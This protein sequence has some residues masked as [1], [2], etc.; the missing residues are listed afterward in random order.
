MQTLPTHMTLR[1]LDSLYESLTPERG[2]GM[3]QAIKA[4]STD[5]DI[6]TLLLIGKVE[7][8]VTAFRDEGRRLCA[9]GRGMSPSERD[10]LTL[11]GRIL[12]ALAST[13]SFS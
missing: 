7:S 2:T 13:C 3:I 4:A 5:S 8:F 12:A 11:H 1:E 6:N 9:E 10:T